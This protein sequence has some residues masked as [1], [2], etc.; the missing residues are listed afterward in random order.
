MMA[1][2]KRFRWHKAGGPRAGE[3]SVRPAAALP[4]I[5]IRPGRAEDAPAIRRLAA[6]DSAEVPPGALLVAEVSG[7]LWAAV[8]ASGGPAIADPFRPSAELVRLLRLR[9]EQLRRPGDPSDARSGLTR[10][11]A[12]WRWR[13][14]A[15]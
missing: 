8:T 5:T 4:D 9:A 6:L 15:A 10:L 14:G 12:S 11:A 3:S 2:R 1:S 7:E 13:A